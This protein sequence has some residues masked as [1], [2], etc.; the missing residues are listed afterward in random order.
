MNSD[1]VGDN[2]PFLLSLGQLLEDITVFNPD[3]PT[4]KDGLRVFVIAMRG[5]GRFLNLPPVSLG[6]VL[7]APID[8]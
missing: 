7:P 1:Q 6:P 3:N 4:D 2:V 8:F 5:D